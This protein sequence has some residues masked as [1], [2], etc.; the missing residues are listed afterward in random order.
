MSLA[1]RSAI[2]FR[3]FGSLKESLL[4]IVPPLLFGKLWEQAQPQPTYNV[5]D[6]YCQGVNRKKIYLLPNVLK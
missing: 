4:L 2:T 1:K 5:R 6:R 3:A